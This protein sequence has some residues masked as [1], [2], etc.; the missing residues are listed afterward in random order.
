MKEFNHDA[1]FYTVMGV[2]D[3]VIFMAI[4]SAPFVLENRRRITTFNIHFFSMGPYE[5]E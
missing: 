2:K 1:S 4:L 3:F 5:A